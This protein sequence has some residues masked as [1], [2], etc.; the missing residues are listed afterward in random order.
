MIGHSKQRG[1]KLTSGTLHCRDDDSFLSCRQR[2]W[3]KKSSNDHSNHWMWF[4]SELNAW[5]YRVCCLSMYLWQGFGR[6]WWRPLITQCY[7]TWSGRSYHSSL[8]IRIWIYLNG[9]LYEEMPL[10]SS[11]WL[12]LWLCVCVFV[13]A[14]SCLIC[15]WRTVLFSLC[16]S[17]RWSSLWDCMAFFFEV[18]CVLRSLVSPPGKTLKDYVC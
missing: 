11:A 6:A 18:A 9:D 3:F 1:H 5:V 15:W 14:L 2:I 16:D 10:V 17:W 4:P 12:P 13:S 7:Y 8:W